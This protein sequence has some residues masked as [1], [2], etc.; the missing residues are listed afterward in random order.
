MALTKQQVNVNF[1]RGLD[2]KTDPW[3]VPIGNFLEL[4]N[5]VFNKQGLLQKRNGFSEIGN[6][7]DSS[8]SQIATYNDDILALG[9]NLYAYNDPTDSFVNKGAF[10]PCDVSTQVANSN[11]LNKIQADGVRAPN[12]LL[13]TT[14][15]ES[16]SVKYTIQNSETGQVVVNPTTVTVTAPSTVT[17]LAK[18][19]LYRNY[20]ILLFTATNGGVNSIRY[21]AID[22]ENLTVT[23]PTIFT[24]IFSPPPGGIG[25]T[26]VYFDAIE[27]SNVLMIAFNAIGGAGV[28]CGAI[29]STLGIYAP[30]QIDAATQLTVIGSCSDGT[31]AY[32]AYYNSVTGV[33]RIS[34]ATVVS[35]IVTAAPGFPQ[36]WILTTFVGDMTN[37]SNQ[38]TNIAS[39]A[40]IYNNTQIQNISGGAYIVTAGN[41]HYL[42]NIVSNTTVQSGLTYGTNRVGATFTLGQVTNITASVVNGTINIISEINANYDYQSPPQTATNSVFVRTCTTAGVMGP[43]PT[44]A[45]KRSVGLWSKAIVVNGQ[46][47]F[48]VAYNKGNL[49]T[50]YTQRT[51]QPCYFLIDL[52]GNILARFAYQNGVGYADR[53][54]ALLSNTSFSGS[55]VANSKTISS[56]ADTSHLRVGQRLITSNFR[57]SNTYIESIDSVSQITVTTPA[58]ATTSTTLQSNDIYCSFLKQSFSQTQNTS[59]G[60][61]GTAII[62]N[63]QNQAA[64]TAKL[65]LYSTNTNTVQLGGNL[66]LSGGILSNYD[67]LQVTENNF[68]INPDSI[69]LVNGGAGAMTAQDYFYRVVYQ[70]TDN[71]GNLNQSATNIPVSITLAGPST[72]NIYIPTLRMTNKQ[73]V[74][75]AIFRLSTAQQAYY[76][77]GNVITPTLNDLTRDYIVVNDNNLDSA[78]VGNEILYSNGD[79]I[80][81]QAPNPSGA[82]AIFDNRLWLA[83]T[84][85]ENQVFYSKQVIPGTP[86]EMSDLFT[87]NISPVQS[88]QG[89]SGPVTCLFP[90][91]DKLIIFKQNAIYYIN[92]VGPDNTG[93]NSQYSEPILITSTVGC[94]N[95]KSIVF[96]QN[97]LMFQSDKGIWLLGRDMQ[98]A[99]IGAPVESF[100]EGALVLSANLIPGTNQ[101]RMPLSTGV[102]LMYDYFFAQWGSFTNIPSQSAIVSLGKHTLLDAYGRVLQEVPNTYNDAGSPV[103]MK[104]RTNWFALGGIQ[105]FQRAY[106]L[107]LLGKYI[108]PHRLIVGVSYDFDPSE[109]QQTVIVP[110]NYN[111]PWGNDPLWGSTNFWGG[112]SQVEKWRVMLQRQKC[113]SI[114]LTVQEQYDPSLGVN[115]G[116]GL[117][118]SGMNFIIGVKR[119]YQT[120]PAVNTAG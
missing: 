3:Q 70:W 48:V 86:I 14:Y 98:T 35:G 23:G 13:L 118:L 11:Y 93:A 111:A 29:T 91:D 67:G 7:N 57:L 15:V 115:A 42:T 103:T 105:G 20:F 37:G 116:A 101:V 73:N 109:T 1:S 27:A 53:G 12:G 36:Q 39:T 114:Q 18:A 19:Y 113:D 61:G 32:F 76:R 38:I 45:I 74:V 60:I 112:N 102:M 63:Y 2:T 108:S 66:A 6:P 99:Y 79:V 89:T 97:G 95:Q 44:S 46:T 55:C 90:M 41:Y 58:I 85:V 9:N 64:Y 83:D 22:W 87:L 75:I 96:M 84:E 40:N 26:G 47:Y 62:A 30:V 25:G 52:D 117:T 82:L 71:Q 54:L 81:N 21:L 88:S 119:G 34:G 56:I 33:G 68:L 4:E 17:G 77:I 28:Y 24:S 80:E 78:I 92:G 69:G 16:G 59:F 50:L 94:T 51:N 43:T 104:F 49:S 72:V 107:F 120:I 31:N 8:V 106:F 5:S 65:G 100:T 110:D 10:Y